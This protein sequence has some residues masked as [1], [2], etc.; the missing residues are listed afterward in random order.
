MNTTTH[1]YLTDGKTSPWFLAVV[2]ATTPGNADPS[3]QV[4]RHVYVRVRAGLVDVRGADG[5]YA[6]VS[7]AQAAAR[8][9]RCVGRDGR[10][11]RVSRQERWAEECGEYWSQRRALRAPRNAA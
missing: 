6:R 5:V 3:W 11:L 8:L 4:G 9:K 10:P 7:V 1:E 2:V